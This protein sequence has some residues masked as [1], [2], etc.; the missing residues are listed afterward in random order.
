MTE[1]RFSPKINSQDRPRWLFRFGLHDG[2]VKAEE[3]WACLFRTLIEAEKPMDLVADG[4]SIYN[5]LMFKIFAPAQNGFLRWFCWL[6]CL[7]HLNPDERFCAHVRQ[8]FPLQQLQFENDMSR[9]AL[10][11]MCRDRKIQKLLKSFICTN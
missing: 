7:P 4:Q 5:V 6:S 3:L 11:L 1:H 8:N 9:L 10:G 2:W